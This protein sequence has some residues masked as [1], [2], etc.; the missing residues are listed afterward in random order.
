MPEYL[1]GQV[2][3]FHS[4]DRD[5]GIRLI[6]GQDKIQ[7]S[8]NAWDWLGRSSYFWEQDPSRAFQYTYE[9]AAGVQKNKTAAKT[10]FIVGAIIDLG[11]CLNLV[12][13]DSLKI[14]EEAYHGL[15][16][17]RDAANQQM[18]VNRGNNR[19]LDCDVINYIHKSNKQN[20]L[21]PYDTIRCAFPEGEPAF[22]GSMI[23]SRLHIQICVYN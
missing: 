15:K 5:L 14:L 10:P 19:A 4:C 3:G 18:P 6:N 9:T 13:V 8:D 11:K 12:E 21:P 16:N 22:P 20:E 7:P 2:V 17:I 23:T 1:S